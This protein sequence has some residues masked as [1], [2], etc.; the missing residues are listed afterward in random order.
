MEIGTRDHPY[1]MII[2]G[3]GPAGLS[4]GILATKKGLS[5]IIFEKDSIPSLPRGETVHD[6]EI[7]DLTL[8]EGV[9][10]SLALNKT[11]ARKFFSPNSLQNF[12]TERPTPSIVFDWKVFIEKLKTNAQQNGASINQKCEVVSLI[13]EGEKAVG[14]KYKKLD[15]SGIPDPV[16]VFGKNIII[17]DGHQS[18]IG[19]TLGIPYQKMNCQIIKCLISNFQGKN[20][21]FEYYFI[22]MGVLDYAPSFPP[23]IAFI[24]PRDDTNCEVG[25]IVLNNIARNLKK[26]DIPNNEELL[27]VWHKFFES[28]PVFSELMKAVIIDEEFATK[29]PTAHVYDK[30]MPQPG[31]FVVGDAAGFVE[32]SG[33]SGISTSM[34]QAQFVIDSIVSNQNKSWDTENQ[35]TL[36]IRFRKSK[37]FTH[38]K[39]NLK[40]TT[41]GKKFLFSW[42]KTCEKINK[43]WNF[44]K[45]IYSKF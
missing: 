32:A 11:A 24:F 21:G 8:G 36:N 10:E 15:Q 45:K 17:S 25:L 22:P 39:K 7:F 35:K 33:G 3:G 40:L 37:I 31:A 6:H 13:S 20:R 38:I 44:I 16:S 26:C 34:Q 43:R 18:H 19:K 42:L 28:Y 2:C 9:L 41:L 30:L 4:A 29:I 5:T 14:I 1:D 27:T 12:N 23:S